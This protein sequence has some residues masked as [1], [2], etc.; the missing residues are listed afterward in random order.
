MQHFMN[1]CYDS[2]IFWYYYTVEKKQVC[3]VSLW[4]QRVTLSGIK[5]IEIW[6]EEKTSTAHPS[7]PSSTLCSKK[8]SQ[9]QAV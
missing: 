3:D 9:K 2:N 8:D 6:S 4:H 1:Q 5:W 7:L